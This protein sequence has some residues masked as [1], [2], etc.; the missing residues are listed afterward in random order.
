MTPTSPG[1]GAV[2]DRVYAR[3]TRRLVPFLFVCYAAAYL[4][5]VNVGFAKLQL[6][7]DL[8]F[9]DTVYGIG[10]GIFFVGYIVFEVPSN[11]LLHKVGAKWW[12]ARIM[13]TW[14]L[15]DRKSV[16]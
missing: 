7:D 16:V 9:S 1:T 12:I 8:A 6:Q 10:A 5:R 4:D 11:L 2:A 15:I 14:A 3:I 13:V